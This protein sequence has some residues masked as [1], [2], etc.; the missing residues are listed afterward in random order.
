MAACARRLR[1]ALFVCLLACACATPGERDGASLYGSL[2][3]REGIADLVD[4]FLRELADD[5][6]I[7]HHFADTDIARLRRQLEDLLC[8][9]SG[10]PCRYTGDP[11]TD[12]HRGLGVSQGDFNALV[13]DLIAAMDAAGIGTGAQNR[14]L[15]RLAPMRGD[16]V[17]GRRERRRQAAGREVVEPGS[18]H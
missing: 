8:E 15:A 4:R 5:R 10:G 9:L 12:V 3:G 18:L 13:E 6:R 1:A 7:A 17:E 14:L 16:I 11:M 2:G